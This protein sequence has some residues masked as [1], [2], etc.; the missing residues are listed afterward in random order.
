MTTQCNQIFAHLKNPCVLQSI[1]TPVSQHF[2]WQPGFSEGRL[3]KYQTLM[4]HHSEAAYPTITPPMRNSITSLPRETRWTLTQSL[5]S[6]IQCG[7]SGQVRMFCRYRDQHK[8]E[9]E[10]GRPTLV[11]TSQQMSSHIRHYRYTHGC[12]HIHSRL[13]TIKGTRSA[14]Q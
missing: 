8:A 3:T 9:K 6:A 2:K 14:H 13:K 5:A 10:K 4:T 12:L 7:E 11:R 1:T